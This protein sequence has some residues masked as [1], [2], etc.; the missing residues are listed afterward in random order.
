MGVRTTG[1]PIGLVTLVLLIGCA[2]CGSPRP[3]TA[4]AAGSSPTPAPQATPLASLTPP[5]PRTPPSRPGPSSPTA[6]RA[7]ASP[8][9]SIAPSG[10]PVTLAAQLSSTGGAGQ[11]VTVDAASSGVT[12]GTVTLW[13]RSGAC[14]VLAGG[15]WQGRLGVNGVSDHH[16]EGDGTTPTGSYGFGS[17]VY[18]LAPDPGVRYAFHRL[19]CGDWW[20]ED[21]ASPTYNTF[22]HVACGATPPFSG[23]SEALWQA[24]TAYQTF[25][26]IDYNANPVVPGAGSG[27]FFHDDIGHGTAGCVSLP[28]PQLLTMLRWLDPHQAPRIVIGTDAEIR[29]F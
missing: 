21:P 28:A 3:V 13:R 16:H 11:L 17:V 1:V 20:D 8:P 24:T 6:L 2:A 26:V 4:P 29:H 23:G 9:P 27:V 15:P 25:A 19:V 22:Q 5:P 14:W 18:G 7:V 10:C 12:V